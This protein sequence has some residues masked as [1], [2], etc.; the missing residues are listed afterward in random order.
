MVWESNAGVGADFRDSAYMFKESPTPIGC[1][2]VLLLREKP[3][4]R[5]V[6]HSPLLAPWLKKEYSYTYT[7]SVGING[8]FKTPF[9][10]STSRKTITWVTMT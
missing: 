1:L 10:F 8:V 5:G 6:K 9:T 4:G 2:P 7:P 3:P